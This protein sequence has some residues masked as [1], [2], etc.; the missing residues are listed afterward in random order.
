VPEVVITS[1]RKTEVVPSS[2]VDSE[3][4]LEIDELDDSNEDD[5]PVKRKKEALG[6]AP[7]KRVKFNVVDSDSEDDELSPAQLRLKAQAAR[8][9]MA[10]EQAS[11]GPQVQASGKKTARGKKTDVGNSTKGPTSGVL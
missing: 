3:M 6:G 1:P 11:K 5:H 9:Q 2:D 7:A 8:G 4:I 10:K